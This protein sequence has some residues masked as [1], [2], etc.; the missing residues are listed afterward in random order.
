MFFILE[1]S[2]Q[3]EFV[4]SCHNRDLDPDTTLDQIVRSYLDQVTS[5]K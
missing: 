5:M 4:Q 3:E 1:K 2:L